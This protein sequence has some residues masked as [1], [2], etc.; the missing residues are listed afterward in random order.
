MTAEAREPH[1][2]VD[3]VGALPR[4]TTVLHI[5]APKTGTTSLQQSAAG[6]RPRLREGG[7]IYPGRYE[8]HRRFARSLLGYSK[9]PWLPDRAPA[10][11]ATGILKQLVDNDRDYALVS[12]EAFS[13]AGARDIAPVREAFTMPT[14]VV[15]TLRPLPGMLLSMWQQRVKNGEFGPLDAWLKDAFRDLPMLHM[16]GG[17]V[18]DES[19]GTNLVGR[20]ADAFGPENMTVVVLDPTDRDHIFRV[21]ED[22]LA[23]PR[24]TL[25]RVSANSGMSAIETEFFRQAA[26]RIFHETGSR[27][28]RG[29]FHGGAVNAVISQR[30]RR[31]DEPALRVPEWVTR[32]AATAAIRIAE[33]IESA[34]VRVVGDLSDLAAAGRIGDPVPFPEDVPSDLALIAAG[35][36]A[37]RAVQLRGAGPQTSTAP[38]AVAAADER[39]GDRGLSAAEAE[40]L[41]ALDEHLTDVGDLDDADVRR[42]RSSAVRRI[43]DTRSAGAAKGAI[44]VQ[45]RIPRELALQAVIGV[46]EGAQELC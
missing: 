14:H 42:L 9:E 26:E 43:L 4:G 44:G 20:W 3:E 1:D 28:R 39:T 34:G 15:L 18:F 46:Y 33:Q 41:A 8:N 2:A 10:H 5:G 7:V 13:T 24:G 29:L 21:F 38:D 19:D 23:Q 35:G 12:S 37:R 27:A 31:T 22:L 16:P 6:S 45:H 11:W 17:D 30:P 32:R 40:F 25:D 36:L